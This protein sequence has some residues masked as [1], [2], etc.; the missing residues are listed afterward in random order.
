MTSKDLPLVLTARD[1]AAVLRV[2]ER[3]ARRLM[4][5]GEL[6]STSNVGGRLRILRDVLLQTLAGAEEEQRG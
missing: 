6:G 1:V 4:R 3:H 5:R 2:S